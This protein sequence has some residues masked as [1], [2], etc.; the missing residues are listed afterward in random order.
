MDISI[1]ARNLEVDNKVKSYISKKLK[2]LQKLYKRIYD[3]EVV[4]ESEK[5]RKNVEILVSLKRTKIVAKE[6]SPDIFASIDIASEKIKKQL[7]R[8]NDRVS[9]RRKRKTMFSRFIPSGM[10]KQPGGIPSGQ[11]Y[12]DMERPSGYNE[13]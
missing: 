4:L 5:E 3:C 1:T 12:E 9:S 11:D 6:T 10:R 7:R 8:L 13:E 2:K